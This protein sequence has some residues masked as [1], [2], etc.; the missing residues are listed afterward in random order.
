MMA[1]ADG[2][3]VAVKNGGRI[4]RMNSVNRKGD[5][6]R[7]FVCIGRADDMN[8]RQFFHT[9]ETTLSQFILMFFYL[10]PSVVVQIFNSRMQGNGTFHI[11]RTGFKL[12]GQDIERR[13]LFLYIFNHVAAQ[14][15]RFHIIQ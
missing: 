10:V 8:I 7:F 1:R 6:P 11:F 13:R 5:N 15:E 2:N 12:E 14:K 3:S 9:F 4:V